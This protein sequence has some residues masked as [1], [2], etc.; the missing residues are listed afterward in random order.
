V[1]ALVFARETPPTQVADRFVRLGTSLCNFYLVED[2]GRVTIVDTGVPAY[3]AQ[4]DRGLEALGRGRGDV[5][6][7]VLT[8][9]HSDHIGFAEQARGELGVPVYV[10]R[11]DENLTTTGKAFGKREAPMLPYL[12]YP[13][14]WKLLAHFS[15]AGLPKPVHEVRTFADGDTLDVPGRPR[16]IHTPGHT[17]GHVVFH[18]ESQGVLALGDLLCTLNPLTGR[19]GPQLLPRALNNSSGT[20]LDSLSKIEGVDAAVLAFGHG[21]PWTGG[22]ADA[23]R[24][25]REVGPT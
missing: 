19:R 16:V 13:Q 3:Y 24:R 1:F 17:A 18:F 15:T 5:D 22:A 4:L 9:G 21:E 7:I 12:R 20:M 14:A 25:A 6:A 23:V 8:H 11:D 10:H 2:G